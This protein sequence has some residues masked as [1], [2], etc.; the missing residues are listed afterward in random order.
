MFIGDVCGCGLFFG[1]EL[2]M[3]CDVKILV[4][5]EVVWVM[6]CMCDFGIFL[7][8]DGFDV[9]VLKF[10]LFFVWIEFE[11]DYVVVIFD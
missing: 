5:V 9:N 3:D 8:M 4:M 7:S 6:N 1:V 2:V 11:V 10:K